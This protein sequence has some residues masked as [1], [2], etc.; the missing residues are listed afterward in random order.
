M[1]IDKVQLQQQEVVNNETVL[2]NINPVTST[3]SVFDINTGS[4]MQET[5]D[6]IWN[7]INSE[8]S[9]VVNSV[10]N[11]SGAVVLDSSDVGLG[12]VDNI[13]FDDIKNWVINF[14]RSKMSNY[15]FRLFDTLQD[16]IDLKNTNDPSLDSVPFYIKQASTENFL[17]YIG[18]FYWDEAH[19]VLLDSMKEIKVVGKVDNSLSYVNGELNVKI[20]PDEKALYVDN[21]PIKTG[22]RIDPNKLCSELINFDCL[23]GEIS[24]STNLLSA[25]DE[26]DGDEVVIYIDG[27]EVVS[28]HG[29]HL[30]KN[31]KLTHSLNKFQLIQTSFG[32]FYTFDSHN[33]PDVNGPNAELALMDRQP[34]IGVVTKTKDEDGFYQIE[35]NSIKT[36]ANGFGLTYYTNHQNSTAG[37]QLGFQFVMN[38]K[39]G[40]VSGMQAG[41]EGLLTTTDSDASLERFY[42]YIITLPCGWLDEINGRVDDRVGSVVTTDD[43]ICR[44]PV[45]MGVPAAA[46]ANNTSMEIYDNKYLGSK[47]ADN[48]APIAYYGYDTD[49]EPTYAGYRWVGDIK[50]DGTDNNCP[51]TTSYLSVNTN[52]LVRYTGYTLLTSEPDDWDDMYHEKYFI[53]RQISD[54]VNDY[55]YEHVPTS[56]PK[57]T[58]EANKYYKKGCTVSV[59][60]DVYRTD[61]PRYHF[62]NVSGLKATHFSTSRI[63]TVLTPDP[64]PT[65][66]T[67]DEKETLG[68][69][70]GKDSLGN[71][72]NFYPFNNFSGGLSVNVGNFLEICPKETG[73]GETYDDSGKVQVRIGKGLCDDFTTETI[74]LSE[75]ID[76]PSDYYSHPERFRKIANTTGELLPLGK[77]YRQ[78]TTEPYD[79]DLNWNNYYIL[80][81]NRFYHV[82]RHYQ[83]KPPF[84]A[85]P[86][87]AY[88]PEAWSVLRASIT[89][90]HLY[91]GVARLI[92]TNRFNVDV[93]GTSIGFDENNKLKSTTILEIYEDGKSF[94]KNQLFTNSE[95]TGVYMANSNFTASGNI[96]DDLAHILVIKEP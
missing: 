73:T 15:Q 5:L 69:F 95:S 36:F 84:D 38:T 49:L 45:H 9:R 46:D 83:A 33:T 79:W 7:A 70:D 44:Y 32:S 74:D 67:M 26:T 66:L 37:K 27:T 86:F 34:A 77:G 87:Y 61:M 62:T 91:A 63:P 78:L 17:A 16:E 20:H 31:W 43:T 35:F 8:L 53:A 40:N 59:D 55:V 30:N 25:F 92:R 58:W 51:S 56:N 76:P 39:M 2:T 96:S 54:T 80:E 88:G 48:W 93:D 89:T 41:S 52:K 82:S 10:N 60:G 81:N 12:N 42:P 72:L 85:E 24:S 1:S 13:S 14:F 28:S 47:I 94:V 11:R 22:L 75:Y 19:E 4:T 50:P 21:G 71:E 23:Y 6:R 68:I 57:P 3:T 90:G 29:H 65:D 64:D 18:Y